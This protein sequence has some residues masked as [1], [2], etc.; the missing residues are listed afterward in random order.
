MT[1][2][3]VVPRR[4]RGRPAAERFA[5]FAERYCGLRLEDFQRE[6]AR[7][8]FADRRELLVLMPR[9]G[10]KTALMAA[11]GL[12]ALLYARA[13]DLRLCGLT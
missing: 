4:G 5:V 7:E 9:G 1:G 6:I 12:S 10:G 13:R 3:V 11:V 8:V 2:G